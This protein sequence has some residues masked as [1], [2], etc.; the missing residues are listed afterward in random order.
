M[1]LP[2]PGGFSRLSVQPAEPEGGRLRLLLLA[3]SVATLFTMSGVAVAEPA[4]E[5]LSRCSQ[6]FSSLPAHGKVVSMPRTVSSGWCW[7]AF[8]VLQRLIVY[9]DEANQHLFRVCAPPEST[10]VE[11][12]RIFLDYAKRHPKELDEEFTDMALTSLTEAF[13]CK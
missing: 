3:F 5:M 1:D 13:P 2:T 8:E 6:G 4:R 12:I 7:G 11:I 10:R 9:S